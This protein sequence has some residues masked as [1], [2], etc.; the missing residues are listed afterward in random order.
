LST[1]ANTW[2]PSEE[3]VLRESYGRIHAKTIGKKLGR[4]VGAVMHRAGRTGLKSRRRWSAE[5][6]QQLRAEWGECSLG[7]I[8]K[9]MSRTPATIYWRAKEIELE[10]G[11]PR[12]LEYLTTAAERTGYDTAPLRRILK[13]HGVRL[14]PAFSRPTGARRHYHVV[15]P[16]DVDDAIAKHLAGASVQELARDHGVSGECLRF[17]LLRARAAGIKMQAPPEQT[18]V[19]WRIPIAA[20]AEVMAWRASQETLM[21]GA[22]R[23]GV[24][25]DTLLRRLLAAGFV[26]PPGKTWWVFKADVDKLAGG[27]R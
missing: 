7:Q 10:L 9:K 22:K 16:Q 11:C 3:A 2:T 18:R 12:G 4:S 19:E 17:W 25:R 6:D 26:K 27:L 5:D 15:D 23:V 8:A 14:L 21:A 13:A 1:F 24:H 20:A